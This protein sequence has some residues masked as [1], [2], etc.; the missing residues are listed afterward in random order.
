M[1]KSEDQETQKNND[2]TESSIKEEEIQSLSPL[3]KISQI[4]GDIFIPI[5]PAIAVTGL[6]MG[7]RGVITSLGVVL[8]P[9]IQTLFSVLTDTVF[10]FLPVFVTWS[11]FRKFGG[12]PVLGIL[13]GLILVSP[14][15][16]NAWAVA[17][18]VASPMMISFFG[19]DF[20][21]FGYQGSVI[22]PL[23]VSLIG[24]WVEKQSRK[25]IPNMLEL[26]AI[27]LI[28]ISSVVFVGLILLG[29]ILHGIETG[30][31]A[32]VKD[33]IGLPFGIGGVIIGFFHQALV[34]TGTHH[35]LGAV[36]ISLL[37]TLGYNPLNGIITAAMSGMIGAAFSIALSKKNEDRNYRT[38]TF[39]GDIT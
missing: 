24:C 8:S 23:L 18:G 19:I 16:P 39:W 30:V 1:H 4:F 35:M 33:F 27:P 36:E 22:A 21:L 10:T 31:G 9:E 37:N 34:I 26:L 15:L 32:L 6:F 14:A 11:A 29:P 17:G 38:F 28:V 13:T 7:L 12:S 5:I 25:F 3:Q 20:A 2:G